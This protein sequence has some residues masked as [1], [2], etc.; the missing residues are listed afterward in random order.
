MRVIVAW[1]LRYR[2]LVL[3]I[4]AGIM[5]FGYT[6][7]S[8]ASFDTLPEFGPPRVE[9]QTEALGLS[10]QEVEQ[11][12]TVPLEADLLHGVA[13][14]DTI[15]SQS[16]PGLSSIVMYFDPGTEVLRA[17]QMVA[18]RLTQAHALPNVS[19]S[20]AMLQPLSSSNRVM[21][22]GLSSADVSLIDMSVLAHWTIRP[23]LLSVPGVANVA[24]WGQRE[25][26]LQ[27]QVD[28]ARMRQNSV[29][30]DDVIETAGN[31]LWVSPLTF[32]DASTPG[33]GGFIDTTNQRLGIQHVFPIH[34]PDD[35][36]KV[37]IQGAQS[38]TGQQLTLGDVAT[39]VQ[40]HQPLIGDAVVE[41][42][43]GLVLV[44]EKFPNADSVQVS[45]DV[46]AALDAMQP[47]LTGIKVDS[48]L[49]RPADYIQTSTV[50]VALALLVA[51]ALV[52]LTIG[53]LLGD[54]R[55]ALIALVTIPLSLAAGGVVLLIA[56]ATVNAVVVAGLV[57]AI[58]VLV[59]DAVV[60]YSAVEARA[61]AQTAADHKAGIAAII[62]D[63]TVATRGPLTVATLVVACAIV[64]ILLAG[65]IVGAFA[66]S[67]ITAFIVSVLVSMVVALTV[68]P[69]LC[70]LLRTDPERLG[71]GSDRARRVR[72]SY[73]R[74]LSRVIDRTRPVVAVVAIASVAAVVLFGTT[75][76]PGAAGS[77]LPAFRDPDVLVHF[78][79]A[80]GTSAQ[81]M[82]RIVAKVTHELR[83]VPGVEDVAGHVGRAVLSDQVV[84][85]HS[86]ELWLSLDPNGDYDKQIDAVRAVV[87]GYPGIHSEIRT[88]ASE[89]VAALL[90]QPKSDLVVRVYGQE[91][92]TLQERAGAVREAVAAVPN[93][94]SAQV[95]GVTQEPTVKVQ[96]D[97]AAAD[98]LGLKPGEVR[99][100]ATS[101]LS[102]IVVGSLFED[103]KV[104]EVV[105][106]TKPDLRK[107][108]AAIE[109]LPI[110]LPTGG[111]VPLGRVAKISVS[112]SPTEI[113]RE[114]VFRY[115]DV[116][117]D[118]AGGDIART[119]ND[120]HS[121]AK[122]LPMP[123]EYRAEVLGDYADR[124]ATQTRWIVAGIAAAIAIF[125]LLQ[126]VFQSWRAAAM[127]FLS[128][129][130]GILGGALAAA[131]T[132]G[133]TLGSIC[134]FLTVLA[135][136]ARSGILLIRDAQRLESSGELSGQA[137][138]LHASSER[139]LP[140]L[141]TVVA[142]I[143]AFVPFLVLG[144]RPGFELIR[145][146]A[147]VLVGGLVTATA[148]ILFAVPA[149]Y[150]RVASHPSGEAEPE[151]VTETP[152]FEPA[153]A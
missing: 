65:G 34:S 54:V 87:N 102:G 31:S 113:R 124:A 83:A 28:P 131:A 137:A 44:V 143:A 97:L 61:R 115:V 104:F 133:V 126:A 47:G 45:K 77:P 86:G 23:R 71:R 51:L 85:V 129:P 94:A 135:I 111:Q 146:M 106:W 68:A 20:P 84:D 148:L 18:E 81:E 117:V 56:G 141:T 122:S 1:S 42:A 27:V 149:M 121:A 125:L 75:I 60:A 57:L 134:G 62:L 5:L 30:L 36:A 89:R 53:I 24:V 52:V 66:P 35:L 13:F 140:L 25:R 114:G 80:P 43:P 55:A 91:L 107:D 100:S 41:D 136:T 151:I 33:T 16:V 40:D 37:A 14:L 153:T 105:V 96:V 79:T 98:Q 74:L 138:I 19:K 8:R 22:V 50:D 12:I 58:G 78:D 4:A 118:V 92:A 70:M 6:Q 144:D 127:V 150:Q 63:A 90:P 147:I 88:F 108:I 123:L 48:A 73:T 76:I 130:A 132:G 46:Q 38:S 99:R 29:R 3:G 95:V 139:M 101:L 145:P 112:P 69:A 17:R 116:A 10:A 7:L 128:L 110:D 64:P 32:L 59:D 93:V 49:F 72:A 11:L 39:V 21:V 15:T 67:M 82:D 142:T 119:A 152:A 120:I 26:Q 2:L 109:K 103:E 9:V